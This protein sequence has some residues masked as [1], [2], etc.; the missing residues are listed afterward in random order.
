MNNKAY[1]LALAAAIVGAAST[2][3]AV[4]VNPDGTGQVLLYP[5]YTVEGGFDTYVS[6]TNTTDRAKAVKVR[7][8][9][10]MNSQE[11]LD[12]NLYLSPND[13]W[14]AVI[15]DDPNSEAGLLRTADTS[16]T[17]PNIPAAGVPFRASQY[18]SEPEED[19]NGVPARGLD[20]TREGYVEIIEMGVLE[21][22]SDL[23]LATEHIDGVPDD[24]AA[25]NA[26]WNAGGIWQSDRNAQFDTASNEGAGGLYGNGVLIN[27]GEGIDASYDAV[28]LETFFDY[29]ETG[30]T[31]HRFP[32][33]VE[34]SLNDAFPP[35]ATIIE[36]NG[37]DVVNVVFPGAPV[38]A[39][40]A[41]LTHDAVFNDYVLDDAINA[42]TDWVINFPTKSFHVNTTP[43][44]APF[45]DPWGPDFAESCDPIELTLYDREERV[46]TP[47][48]LDFSPAPDREGFELCKEVNVMSFNN[49]DVLA[50]SPRI[51]ANLNTPF[52]NG[53]LRMEFND[54]AQVATDANGTEVYGLPVI[55]FAV[56]KYVNGD[57]GGVL[58]NYA[59]LMNHKYSRDVV[60]SEVTAD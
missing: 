21:A 24:C 11:V 35:V 37:T 60:E 40:S 57:L 45:Q 43:A 39:V 19:G 17:V 33:S 29:A 32:G 23:A 52:E 10:G 28:A 27:V 34:P 44:I 51:G 7:F 36:E 3:H 31:L 15:T 58:S 20:R 16:C 6:V 26:A 18:Q 12:F 30:D 14:T 9:E 48:L 2:A 54:P 13:M 53:W 38:R 55:G 25:L 49:S 41:A 42:G 5:Y 59:G 56:Q 50:A 8:L 46:D 4:N 47:D 1:S 22:G